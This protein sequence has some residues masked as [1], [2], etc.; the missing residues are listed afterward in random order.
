MKLR[1]LPPKLAERVE[2]LD[3]A[4]AFGPA[5]ADAAGQ[6]DH[7]HRSLRP[8]P[9]CRFH[10]TSGRHRGGVE[11]ICPARASLNPA[12]DG[13]TILRQSDAAGAQIGLD[14]LVLRGSKP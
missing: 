1:C 9:P 10:G 5:A 3:D 13:K 8:E 2:R 4:R 6:R 14:L 11:E 7:R 12:A